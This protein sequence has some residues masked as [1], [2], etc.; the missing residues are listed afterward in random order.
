MVESILVTQKGYGWQESQ[1]S[2]YEKSGVSPLKSNKSDQTYTMK[3]F[4]QGWAL[5]YLCDMVLNCW[6][7]LT[8]SFR[9][10]NHF[11]YKQ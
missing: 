9:L 3:E 1:S 6:N 5:Y 2:F 4:P 11:S 8:Y 7:S 10:I